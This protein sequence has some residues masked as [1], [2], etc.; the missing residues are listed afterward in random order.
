MQQGM[1]QYAEG[2]IVGQE[3]VP[4]YEGADK[5][6]P[7]QGQNA[8][9]IMVADR[10]V[11][12]Y[13]AMS[14]A[15]QVGAVR[16]NQRDLVPSAKAYARCKG[17]VANKPLK[18]NED[19]WVIDESH[20]RYAIYGIF[21]G[22]DGVQVAEYCS[23]CMAPLILKKLASGASEARA[24]TESFQEVDM[25]V[26]GRTAVKSGAVAL[27]VLFDKLR[28][29]IYT[30]NVGNA[31]ALFINNNFIAE[32]TIRPHLL[33]MK[34]PRFI[35][36]RDTRARRAG[37]CISE[38]EVVVNHIDFKDGYLI[39]VSEGVW[40]VLTNTD[41]AH[42]ASHLFWPTPNRIAKELVKQAAAKGSRDDSTAL[43]VKII[44]NF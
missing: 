3:L 1:N 32:I 6:R 28:R 26:C 21:D 14:T 38:P 41:V 8:N 44:S 24:L 35:G 2:I 30:A 22:H 5:A 7:D 19:R 15:S 4:Y 39:L 11:P 29:I 20:P 25:A 43:V 31:R 18:A 10:L 13:N 34:L 9:G 17:A 23:L 27:V 36:L 12:Y 42:T 37:V 33:G 40:N 16:H